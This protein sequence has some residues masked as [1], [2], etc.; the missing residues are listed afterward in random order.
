MKRHTTYPFVLALV[1]LLGAP[2][3][4]RADKVDD[5]VKAEMQR[6]RITGVSVAVVKDGK[7][8]KTGGYGLANAELNIPATPETVYQIGSVSKQLIA[9]GILILA[10]DGRL[11]V[12]DK[13]SKYVEGTPETWKDITLRHLLTHTS[14]IQREAPGFNPQKVQADAD[15]IRTAY[16][17]PLR[18]AP[19]EK[20]EYSIRGTSRWQTSFAR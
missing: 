19:G 15:V 12:D 13:I 7:I 17:L 16:P 14:G 1:L 8:I 6:Q 18:F 5:L 20:W 11:S 9:A 4:V 2:T 10:Q 3:A